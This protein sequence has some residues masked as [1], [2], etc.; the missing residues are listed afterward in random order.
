[1]S[2]LAVCFTLVCRGNL[3]KPLHL[4]RLA[5]GV[6]TQSLTPSKMLDIMW[7][8]PLWLHDLQPRGRLD[9]GFAPAVIHL[10]EGP[11]CAA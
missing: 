11:A 9:A 1:M 5:M 6:L 7:L 2:A 10:A 8:P 4:K 3:K